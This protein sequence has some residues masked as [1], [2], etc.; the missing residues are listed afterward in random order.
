MRWRFRDK[1]TKGRIRAKT[2]TLASVASL[3]GYVMRAGHEP[4][5]AFSIM[6]NNVN[7]KVPGA[8]VAI[9]NCVKAL[10]AEVAR[11]SR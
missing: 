10:A 6:V 9:D 4:P 3:S 2:G 11:T 7:G 1:R 5:V 8:R